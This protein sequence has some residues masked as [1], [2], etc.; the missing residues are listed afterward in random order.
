MCFFIVYVTSKTSKSEET[1]QVSLSRKVQSYRLDRIVANSP[2]C[3]NIYW[4]TIS[5]SDTDVWVLLSGN[6]VD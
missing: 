6:W 5:K 3:V 4:N 2:S 1:N